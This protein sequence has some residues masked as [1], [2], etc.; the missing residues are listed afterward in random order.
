[1][2]WHALMECNS[3]AA[4]P[5][6]ILLLGDSNKHEGLSVVFRPC[7]R[8]FCYPVGVAR[9]WYLLVDAPD[10]SIILDQKERIEKVSRSLGQHSPSEVMKL[11]T[12][13]ERS[14]LS[15]SSP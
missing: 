5:S 13:S 8:A 14:C 9:L 12:M 7:A 2:F 1:M 11:Q 3:L 6:S 10:A 15:A 4:S